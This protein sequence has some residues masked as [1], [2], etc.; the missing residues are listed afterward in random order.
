MKK[1]LLLSSFLAFAFGFTATTASAQKVLSANTSAL[2]SAAEIVSNFDHESG[3]LTV[4]THGKIN[5]ADRLMVTVTHVN[6]QKY[7]SERVILGRAGFKLQADLSDAPAGTFYLRVLGRQVAH[8]NRF[9][10]R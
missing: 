10:K 6:G 3:I 4:E 8:A 2:T 5:V 9:D 1:F 7:F